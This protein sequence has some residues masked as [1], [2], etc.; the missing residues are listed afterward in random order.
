MKRNFLL[1]AGASLLLVFANAICGFAQS[2]NDMICRIGMQYQMSK[3]KSWGLNR[4]VVITVEPGTP[5]AKAGLMPGDIIEKINSTSTIG[6]NEVQVNKMIKAN[7]D[8]ILLEV[9]NFGRKNKPVV[10]KRSC[11]SRYV[12]NETDLASAFAFY[13]LEDQ[14]DRK[15]V[16]PF[17]TK[18]DDKFPLQGVRTFA[19]AASKDKATEGI[20]KDI[21]NIVA[22][23]L[24]KMGLKED[25]FNP[26]VVIDCFYSMTKNKDFN[27]DYSSEVPKMTFRYSFEDHKM[28]PTPFLPVGAPKIAATHLLTMG[29]RI[30]DAKNTD[31][32]IWLCESDELLSKA[33]SIQEYAKF[34]IPMM[35]M[36]FPF[37]RYAVNPVYLVSQNRHYYTGVN[38][39][40]SDPSVVAGFDPNSPAEKAGIKENDHIL[41][42][43][44]QEFK[45]NTAASL[46]EDYKKFI[47]ETLKYR[48]PLT[49]FTDARGVERC[50]Y[51]D[52]RYYN[53][54]AK[55]FGSTKKFSTP[56][57]YIFGFRP[58][59]NR[60]QITSIVFEVNN[61]EGQKSIIVQPILV[62]NSYVTLY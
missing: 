50:R 48:D 30:L 46:S 34:S 42:I 33:M 7:T 51:W 41:S 28:V 37:V 47:D 23:Q 11:K 38:Y 43:N 60:D 52:E 15:I 58:Y 9:S 45:Q 53:K 20:D 62:D 40:I 26:D 16:Y 32:T 10:L 19:F 14:C 12:F 17:Y 4:P 35:L 27:K 5:A 44:G 39:N 2:A 13:S 57:A 3:D 59:V 1:T 54:V 31:H 49:S 24:T 29:L 25:S 18:H 21:Y 22:G 55:L 36:Q 8:N 61:R 6:L 56:F